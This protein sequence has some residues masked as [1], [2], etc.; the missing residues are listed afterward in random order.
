MDAMNDATARHRYASVR[1]PDPDA[2]GAALS[3]LLDRIG[4]DGGSVI[5]L[6]TQA[7]GD[8]GRL[9]YV[10][11]VVYRA[12]AFGGAALIDVPAQ[13]E[14]SMTLMDEQVAEIVDELQ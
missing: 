5:H 8:A 2:F 7:V 9:L 1:D 12:L 10:G 3:G 11:H 6:S 13:A 14:E 4:D